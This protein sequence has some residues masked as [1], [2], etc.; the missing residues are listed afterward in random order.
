M[1]AHSDASSHSTNATA[2]MD[3]DLSK[4]RCAMEMIVW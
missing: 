4:R 2:G 3:T 1:L